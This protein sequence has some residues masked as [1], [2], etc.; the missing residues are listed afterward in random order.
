[1]PTWDEKNATLRAMPQPEDDMRE[2]LSGAIQAELEARA[3]LVRLIHEA[4]EGGMSRYKVMDATGLSRT[5][6]R[7]RLDEHSKPKTLDGRVTYAAKKAAERKAAARAAAK[8]QAEDYLN[9]QDTDQPPGE[10]SVSEAARRLK[11]GKSRT[12]VTT[13]INN[14]RVDA[15]D[16]DPRKVITDTKGRVVV[17]PKNVED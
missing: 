8:K 16:G 10:I 3:A 12:T 2:K 7:N 1:M 14:G 11:M 6:V 9:R 17:R 15:T 4:V 5:Q 13:W